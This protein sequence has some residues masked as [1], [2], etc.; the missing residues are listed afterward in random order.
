MHAWNP[1]FFNLVSVKFDKLLKIDE[2]T[3]MKSNV[4]MARILIKTPYSEISRDPFPVLVDDMNFFIRIKE[5]SE[6]IKDDYA[7][8]SEGDILD[9]D[10]DFCDW[11]KS[12]EEG[13]ERN[14]S[15]TM[16]PFPGDEKRK[17]TP[18]SKER[19]FLATNKAFKGNGDRIITNILKIEKNLRW[20]HL[21]RYPNPAENGRIYTPHNGTFSKEFSKGSDSVVLGDQGSAYNLEINSQFQKDNAIQSTQFLG[22]ELNAINTEDSFMDTANSLSVSIEEIGD[23]EKGIDSIALDSA[24]CN[25]MPMQWK[26]TARK[27][28]AKR[29]ELS[30]SGEEK[31]WNFYCKENKISEEMRRLE[32]NWKLWKEG[33]E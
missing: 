24:T 28:K 14:V 9:S 26:K 29:I 23:L 27:K 11:W 2:S 33:T 4:H 12:E 8:W 32:D 21:P 5:E 6:L 22:M 31:R 1:E 10:E 25:K 13:S 16:E 3:T 17:D 19:Q 18:E 20:L 15:K 30:P 7:D